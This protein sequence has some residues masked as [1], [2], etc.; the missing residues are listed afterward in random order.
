MFKFNLQRWLDVDP[1][2]GTFRGYSPAGYQLPA[3]VT[4]P[5]RLDQPSQL[6]AEHLSEHFDPVFVND[7]T[8]Y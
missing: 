1:L 6:D 7:V 4:G 5:F 3:D 2:F 8:R